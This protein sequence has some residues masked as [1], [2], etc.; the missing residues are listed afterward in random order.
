L[1]GW[2]KA[3]QSPK[4]VPHI[5]NAIKYKIYHIENKIIIEILA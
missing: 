5:S 2:I 1:N 4:F 3:S